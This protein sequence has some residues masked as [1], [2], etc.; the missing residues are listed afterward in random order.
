VSTDPNQNVVAGE[1]KADRLTK[2]RTI[3]DAG[4]GEIFWRNF[5]AGFS[6]GLGTF[7]FYILFLFVAG[8]AFFQFAG[9]VISPL[10]SSFS[11]LNKSLETIEGIKPATNSVFP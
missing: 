9:P 6:R 7:L 5:L 4:A 8:W 11:S 3:Y 1:S 2:T 10:F